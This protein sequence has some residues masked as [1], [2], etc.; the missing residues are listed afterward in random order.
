MSGPKMMILLLVLAAMVAGGVSC[1]HE[2]PPVSLPSSLGSAGPQY[3]GWTKEERQTFYHR[4]IGTQFIPYDWFVALKNYSLITL[5]EDGK[6]RPHPDSGKRLVD[7]VQHYG[8]IPDPNHPDHLPVGMAR[9]DIADFKTMAKLDPPRVGFNCAFCHTSRFAYTD[10]RNRKHAITIEG[11]SSLQY[12]IRFLIA[13][14]KSLGE[15]LK[16]KEKLVGFATEVL[17]REKKPVNEENIKNLAGQVETELLRLQTLGRPDP[18]EWGFGRLDALGR[19]GNLTFSKLSSDNV[20]HANAPVSITQIWG[21][22]QYDWVQWNG[23]IQHPLA[24]NIGQ[25][26]GVGA[27]LFTN[28]DDHLSSSFDPSKP[29]TLD[30]FRSDPFRSSV[31]LSGLQ[32]V[33]RLVEKLSPPTW[34]SEFPTIDEGKRARGEELYAKRCLHCHFAPPLPKPTAHGQTLHVTMIP[35]DEIGTDRTMAENFSN[36]KADTGPLGKGRMAAAPAIQTITTGIMGRAGMTVS[37]SENVWRA[38]ICKKKKSDTLSPLKANPMFQGKSGILNQLGG[39]PSSLERECDLVYM[40]RPHR[41]VWATAPFLHN[42]SIPTLFDL[43]SPEEERPRCFEIGPEF[44]FDPKKVGFNFTLCDPTKVGPNPLVVTDAFRF[45]TGRTGNS[46]RGHQFRGKFPVTNLPF[47][48]EVCD[49][50]QKGQREKLAGSDFRGIIGCGLTP[51]QRYDIIEYLKT[52]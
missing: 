11:G 24:R 52:L 3:Q 19:G 32:E 8:M 6:P 41:A 42:G 31:D 48:D 10:L 20:R 39:S 37:E 1:K 51:E 28:P 18:L 14:L 5:G 15:T 13:V 25:V 12:N 2:P 21:A 34:P 35:L 40:A 49:A 9:A 36:R 4:S 7:T 30:A 50:L 27:D 45:D 33:E 17:T 23:S 29:E 38:E 26:I 44:E 16:D 46:N 43:L 47:S 22:W